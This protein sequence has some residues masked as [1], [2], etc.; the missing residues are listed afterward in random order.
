MDEGNSLKNFCPA[1]F[2]LFSLITFYL[3]VEIRV[4]CNVKVFF[5][6]PT[7]TTWEKIRQRIHRSS[8]K[9]THP[10]ETP[11]KTSKS[12]ADDVEDLEIV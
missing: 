3:P 12:S 11:E 10:G 6:Q 7:E 9:V 4:S 8:Y 2:F 5:P 1:K